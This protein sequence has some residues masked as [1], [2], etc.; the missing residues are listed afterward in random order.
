M[1][2]LVHFFN[3]YLQDINHCYVNANYVRW[4]NIYKRNELSLGQCADMGPRWMADVKYDFNQNNTNK[5]N[6][7][8]FVDVPKIHSDGDTDDADWEPVGKRICDGKLETETEDSGA[9]DVGSCSSRSTSSSRAASFVGDNDLMTMESS[10]YTSKISSISSCSS[11]SS[12]SLPLSSPKLVECANS[13]LFSMNENFRLSTRR[14][15][16]LI[17]PNRSSSEVNNTI[18]GSVGRT[19][20]GGLINRGRIESEDEDD[21][22]LLDYDELNELLADVQIPL[23]HVLEP[24]LKEGWTSR[25]GPNYF[26]HDSLTNSDTDLD[27]ISEVS[28]H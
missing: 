25:F 26:S 6:F 13:D 7:A 5:T 15:S 1:Y 24:Y 18:S 27:L 2:N 23:D 16:H 21:E 22:H 28:W 4:K 11:S 19:S 9:I 8:N 12:T 10:F 20:L 17:T 3:I 14:N